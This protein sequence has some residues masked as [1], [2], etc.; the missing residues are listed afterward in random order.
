[1]IGRLPGV[2]ASHASETVPVVLTGERRFPGAAGGVSA[3]PSHRTSLIRQ[4]AG[5]A[6]ALLSVNEGLY[7][8]V[9]PCAATVVL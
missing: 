2:A 9:D 7:G 3:E 1:M 8:S 6:D 4:F 5:S